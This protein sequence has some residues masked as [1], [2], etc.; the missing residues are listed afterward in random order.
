MW[1]TKH[2]VITS[3]MSKSN[4]CGLPIHSIVLLA[5]QFK[6]E[7]ATLIENSNCLKFLKKLFYRSSFKTL[8]STS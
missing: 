8:L 4:Y 2:C 1:T 6:I 3:F 5:S 7:I